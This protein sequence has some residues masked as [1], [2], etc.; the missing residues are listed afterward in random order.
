MPKFM[1]LNGPP[2]CGKD[3]AAEAVEQY[4]GCDIAKHV[5]LST[6]LKAIVSSI[7]GF[8]IEELEK[9]KD[10]ILPNQKLSYRD[11]QIHT[12]SQLVPVFGEDWLGKWLVNTLDDYEQ[13]YFVL[14][15]GGRSADIRPLLRIVSPED[16]LIVQI[17]REGCSFMGDIRSY[18]T[19]QNVR[20]RPT[21]NKNLADFK[22]E[23]V[24]FAGEFFGEA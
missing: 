22:A 16:I 4:F 8:P 20:T 9:E 6:P 18:I 19:A 24:D 11:A 21:V 17:M 3:T 10:S 7:F 2:R 15:D 14:S 1:I 23:M 13:E 12:F 5:K